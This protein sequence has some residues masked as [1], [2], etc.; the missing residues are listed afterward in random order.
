[1]I[2]YE[3]G[4]ISKNIYMIDVH[5]WKHEKTT[6]SFIIF[7]E[8]IAIL[9]PGGYTS[10]KIVEDFINKNKIDKN[11]V[12]YIFVTHRHN[13]HSSG[14][15][16]LVNRLK[17][18]KIY[19]HPITLENLKDPEKI[20]IATRKMYGDYSEDIEIVS[21][22][23]MEPI[24]D[25]ETFELGR[26][27]VIEAIYSPGHTSD[28]FAI[29]ERSESFLFAGD[30]IGLFSPKTKEIIPNSFPPSFK[31]YTYKE[32]IKKLIQLNPKITGFSHFGAVSNADSTN[33]LKKSIQVLDEWYDYIKNNKEKELKQKYLEKFELF[34]PELKELIFDIVIEGFKN[35]LK[36]G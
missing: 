31:F 5:G 21:E 6:S 26:D 33:I 10:G 13:D 15:S 24:R 18:A 14:A 1:M 11:L 17:D 35:G 28:H 7:G 19:A 4:K 32:G 29:F 16:Y 9:D 23:K 3:D 22:E 34:S 36:Q 27:I 8:K 25:G 12:K 2:F 20:N 30:G